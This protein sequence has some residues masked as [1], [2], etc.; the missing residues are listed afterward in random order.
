M[1]KITLILIIVAMVFS[2]VVFAEEAK[3]TTLADF[4]ALSNDNIISITM[5]RVPY[6][7]FETRTTNS[8]QQIQ[9]FIDI[10]QNTTISMIQDSSVGGG[11]GD[12]YI[13]VFK[14]DGVSY[15]RIG[16][17]GGIDSYSLLMNRKPSNL[18]RLDDNSITYDLWFSIDKNISDWAQKEVNTAWLFGLIPQGQFCDYTQ[19]ITRE[20]FCDIAANVLKHAN[21]AQSDSTSNCPFEDTDSKNVALLW[22]SKIIN[23]KSET[24]FAPNTLLTRE[25]AVSI[26]RRIYSVIGLTKN[27]DEY[28][29]TDDDDISDWAKTDANTMRSAGIMKGVSDN[30]FEP[31]ANFTIEQA[32]ATM[33]RL[34]NQYSKGVTTLKLVDEAGNLILSS[35][36]LVG[37]DIIKSNQSENYEIEVHFTP[38]GTNKFSVAT[39]WISMY[40]N[41][42]CIAIMNNNEIIVKPSVFE[43]MINDSAVISGK[44]S[45]EQA[46]Q[47]KD[48]INKQIAE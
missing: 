38:N 4:L 9:K 5:H 11:S 47:L 42:H 21:K 24:E 48:I 26:L 25:E 46:T 28:S 44:F 14:N 7:D 40:G 29:Y 13:E 10:A 12:L 3:V 32:I 20:Q 8:R 39:G 1:R 6:S 36:D 22:N 37:C 35:D 19:N 15:A 33:L 45:L 23:G 17:D 41:D 30:F 2:S 16:H 34:F 27:V 31:K 43:K 18:F